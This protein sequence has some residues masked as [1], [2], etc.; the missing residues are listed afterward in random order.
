MFNGCILTTPLGGQT[1]CFASAECVA[2]Y[3]SRV[4]DEQGYLHSHRG[5]IYRHSEYVG[6]Q[7]RL[8][9]G[10]TTRPHVMSHRPLCLCYVSLGRSALP[11][12]G[13]GSLETGSFVT[14]FHR[15]TPSGL[16]PLIM[17]LLS[18]SF[19]AADAAL[20]DLEQHMQY[21][22]GMLTNLGKLPPA[23]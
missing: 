14:R 13:G 23:R 22:V 6:R 1:R 4:G 10:N 11:E 9:P 5:A 17:P 16:Q 19:I 2:Q 21:V 7:L 8:V 15:R 20:Q 18:P 12:G 3:W